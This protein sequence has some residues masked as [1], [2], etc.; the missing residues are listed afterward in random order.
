LVE[1]DEDEE[2]EG[3]PEPEATNWRWVNGGGFEGSGDGRTLNYPH[4]HVEGYREKTERKITGFLYVSNGEVGLK[5]CK[6]PGNALRN[7]NGVKNRTM[8]LFFFEKNCNEAKFT[9]NLKKREQG[10][11]TLK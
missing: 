1:D 8:R 5:I 11:R 3:Y 4:S 6:V 2:C 7:V 10:A 9:A